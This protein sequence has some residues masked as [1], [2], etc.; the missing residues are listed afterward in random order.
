M[1]RDEEEE[2]GDNAESGGE[3][4]VAGWRLTD[5]KSLDGGENKVARVGSS[6]SLVVGTEG[7]DKRNM[8][9]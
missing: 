7:L 4:E 2:E 1:K 5:G 6:I 3:V 9:S 8:V